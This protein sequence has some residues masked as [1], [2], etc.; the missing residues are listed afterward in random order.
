M[1]RTIINK[2][3]LHDKRGDNFVDFFN[4]IKQEHAK[5]TSGETHASTQKTKNMQTFQ[6][7]FSCYLKDVEED[8]IKD[9]QIQNID[10]HMEDLRR[11]ALKEYEDVREFEQKI[12]RQ[13]KNLDG[14]IDQ[15]TLSH[16]NEL[17][18]LYGSTNVILQMPQ[19]ELD[20]EEDNEAIE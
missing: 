12:V 11:N 6:V 7:V 15:Q 9:G 5:L 13:E 14:D 8:I 19:M 10:G 2:L 1:H 16:S 4:F 18:K 20:D 17:N 3:I